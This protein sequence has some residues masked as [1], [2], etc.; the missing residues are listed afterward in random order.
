VNLFD[1]FMYGVG[2][3][4]SPILLRPF[5]GLLYHLWAIGGDYCGAVGGMNEWHGK[6]KFLEE[7][8]CSAALSTTDP[9]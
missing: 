2:L 4:P 9:T 6:P 7:T 8:C 3:E 1:I 5:I